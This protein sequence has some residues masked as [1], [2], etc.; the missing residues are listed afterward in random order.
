MTYRVDGVD[1]H[2]GKTASSKANGN[3]KK[4]TYVLG[5]ESTGC[6][7]SAGLLLAQAKIRAI[8]EAAATPAL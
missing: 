8:V 2:C 3:G 6:D 5:E 1:Y 4:L 7:V